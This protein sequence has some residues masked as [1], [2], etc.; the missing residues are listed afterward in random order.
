MIVEIVKT[1]DIWTIIHN[2]PETRNAMD[3]ESTDFL[4][5]A[6]KAF[7]KRKEEKVGVFYRAGRHG[8]FENI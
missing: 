1:Y 6:F 3:P 2:R 7:N 4:L 5:E 8:D